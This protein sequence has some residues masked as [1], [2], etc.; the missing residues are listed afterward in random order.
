MADEL[1]TRP[2]LVF[3]EG[4][5]DIRSTGYGDQ[6]GS[7]HISFKDD[8]LEWGDGENHNYRFMNLPKSEMEAIR[9]FLNEWL[10]AASVEVV[11][12]A[13]AEADGEDYME[14]CERHDDRARAAM[15]ACGLVS[16]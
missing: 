13:I 10:P 16:R 2:V 11:G 4:L 15:K 12:R 6:N 5:I 8:N 3:S 7:G 14:D 1:K 9:D